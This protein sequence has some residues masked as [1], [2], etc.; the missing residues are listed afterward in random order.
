MVSRF[1]EDGLVSSSTE[2]VA[3]LYEELRTRLS[4]QDF[5]TWLECTPC[6]FYPPDRFVLT[7]PN[8]FRKAWMEKNF[9]DLLRSSA[10]TIFELEVQ[11]EFEVGSLAVSTVEGSRAHFEEHFPPADVERR[12]SE[13][14]HP[15]ESVGRAPTMA[16]SEHRSFDVSP[17]P[18]PIA[19]KGL[20]SEFLF[21]TFVVGPS[22]NVAHAAAIAICDD[23]AS[24]YNPLFVYGETGTGKTHLLHAICHRLLDATHLRIDYLSS[25]EF[26]NRF[27]E[28][29]A[30]PGH[31][32]LQKDTLDTDVLVL[33][34]IQFLAGKEKTQDQLFRLFHHLMEQR[35]QIIVSSRTSPR[36]TTGFQ[37][38]LTSRF[39]SGLVTRL[40]A[41]N[42]ELRVAILLRKARLRHLNLS[43]EVAEFLAT[44]TPSS[45][46]ELEG[47]L[48]RVINAAATQG[49]PLDLS[50][51]RAAL[52]DSLNE[53]R[54]FG[55]ITVSHILRAV[56]DYYQLKPKDLLS[57]SKVRSVVLPRQIGMFL[58]R[59]LT[60]LSLE[61]I[62]MH[63]G[64][65]DHTTVLYAQDR[66]ELLKG[67]NAQIKGDL[68]ALRDHIL[69]GKTR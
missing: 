53:D 38:R 3:L 10:R 5:K 37:G 34:D 56:Q 41:P 63:F 64:G 12:D 2:P 17:L 30:A 65:R 19:R 28:S 24:S 66:I 39:Q 48:A 25:E 18:P 60:Q 15:P 46:R 21:D 16:R 13:A 47:A 27:I 44:E 36:E 1:H 23:L 58:A 69:S 20:N 68:L 54:S 32:P 26:L 9:R 33:D 55:T 57:R 29:I 52:K 62:G 43:V 6:R 22:N 35:K 11:I 14:P 4:Q 45:A 8:R 50:T 61:E 42:F 51:A 67:S 7:T 49:S 31:R 40:E 59:E